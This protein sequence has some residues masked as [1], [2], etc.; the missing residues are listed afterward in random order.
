MVIKQYDKRPVH[1]NMKKINKQ[2]SVFLGVSLAFIAC[3]GENRN[4]QNRKIPSE[5]SSKTVQKDQEHSG[6]A[7]DSIVLGFENGQAHKTV[8]M[9]KGKRV[10]FTF[11]IKKI[12]AVLFAE[13]VPEQQ[14]G[15]VRFAQIFMPDG[16]ADGPFGNQLEYKLSHKGLYRLVVTENQMVGTPYYGKFTLR[17]NLNDYKDKE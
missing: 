1:G 14:D 11:E 7:K 13:V 12:P 9:E 15:N 8:A 6:L 2:F 4:E 3:A 5:A 17:L 16:S 10:T